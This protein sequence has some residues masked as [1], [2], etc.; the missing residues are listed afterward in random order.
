M[1]KVEYKTEIR[2]NSE[3]DHELDVY[4][5]HICTLIKQVYDLHDLEQLKRI[6]I[7]IQRIILK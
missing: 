4:Y 6:N 2:Q 7:N 1:G 3:K 5:R